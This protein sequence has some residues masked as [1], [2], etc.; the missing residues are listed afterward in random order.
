[1]QP[2]RRM[3][4]FCIFLL[5]LFTLLFFF[6]LIAVD[7]TS[8]SYINR[9]NSCEESIHIFTLVI[10]CILLFLFV[11]FKHLMENKN[12]E[13]PCCRHYTARGNCAVCHDVLLAVGFLLRDK[14]FL[15]PRSNYVREWEKKTTFMALWFSDFPTNPRKMDQLWLQW[16]GNWR[17]HCIMTGFRLLREEWLFTSCHFY[18]GLE[19]WMDSL[20]RGTR[21]EVT[22]TAKL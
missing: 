14:Y 10:V 1:M 15:Y 18:N 9:L 22:L 11:K 17:F 20:P 6:K 19:T 4:L 3:L 12:W 13:K 7:S 2:R 8:R 21:W 5:S 16:P